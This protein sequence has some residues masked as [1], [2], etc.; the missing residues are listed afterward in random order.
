MKNNIN[1]AGGHQLLK[2]QGTYIF[3]PTKMAEI[4]FYS[5]YSEL[6]DI[7]PYYYGYVDNSPR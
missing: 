6:N 7:I 5:K 3:K 4:V 1:Q 2:K